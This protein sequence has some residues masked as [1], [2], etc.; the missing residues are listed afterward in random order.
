M[1][2]GLVTLPCSAASTADSTQFR[3]EVRHRVR[4]QIEQSPLSP[5]RGAVDF[6]R[7]GDVHL[8]WRGYDK[9]ISARRE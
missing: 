2:N 5:A 4:P 7:V 9:K 8:A 6:K 3:M 1:I